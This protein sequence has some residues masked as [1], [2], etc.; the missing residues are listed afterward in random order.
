MKLLEATE[1]SRLRDRGGGASFLWRHDLRQWWRHSL[2]GEGEGSRG[3]ATEASGCDI[4][5][6][7]SRISSAA[8]SGQ[9]E[10]ERDLGERGCGRVRNED[11]DPT[12]IAEV[13]CV[14]IVS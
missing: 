14:N 12:S 11:L 8:P 1:A 4:G 10:R 7:S 6:W 9:V 3:E 2:L 13:H 5:H